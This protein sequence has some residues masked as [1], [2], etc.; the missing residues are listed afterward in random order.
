MAMGIIP[1]E[2][3]LTEE[4]FIKLAWALSR[5]TDLGKAKN[6]MLSPIANEISEREMYNEYLIFQGSIPEV[7]AF[8]RKLHKGC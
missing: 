5:T 2:K 3:V 1:S 8:I 7:E 4:A 6:L